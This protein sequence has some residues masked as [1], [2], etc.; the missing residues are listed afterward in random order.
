M[1]KALAVDPTPTSSGFGFHGKTLYETDVGHSAKLGSS[2]EHERLWDREAEKAG[3][4]KGW[5]AKQAF[6]RHSPVLQT[7][8]QDIAAYTGQTLHPTGA[9]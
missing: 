5:A 9:R 7:E 3:P 1:A 4:S 8:K 2:D 6:S